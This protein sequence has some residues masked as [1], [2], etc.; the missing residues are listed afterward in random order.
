MA[1]KGINITQLAASLGYSPQ[2]ARSIR[3]IHIVGATH[4]ITVTR[5]VQNPGRDEPARVYPVDYDPEVDPQEG[6]GAVVADDIFRFKANDSFTTGATEYLRLPKATV[7]VLARM[8]W[9]SISDPE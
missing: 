9:G 7:Q 2:Q 3:D 1:S 5:F 6:I 4:Q 8:Q